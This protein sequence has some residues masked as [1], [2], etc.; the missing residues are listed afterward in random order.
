[1]DA[2]EFGIEHVCTILLTT[3]ASM[4]TY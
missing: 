2:K 4:P 3:H 1:V